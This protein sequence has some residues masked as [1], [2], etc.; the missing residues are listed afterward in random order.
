LFLNNI[1]C[2]AIAKQLNS[3]PTTN[4]QFYQIFLH[5]HL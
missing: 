2:L 3:S 5:N 1:Y 4:E